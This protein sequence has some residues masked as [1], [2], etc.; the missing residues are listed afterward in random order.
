[1]VRVEPPRTSPAPPR[2]SRLVAGLGLAAATWA[3]CSSARPPAADLAELGEASWYGIEE[4]GRP[5]ANGEPMDPGAMT[6]AHPSLPF[7]TLVEV[8]DLSTGRS[9]EVRINDRGPF[10]AG[11]IIDL[12]H[13][14]ARRLGI[15]ARGVASVRIVIAARAPAPVFTVQ[16]G[17]YRSEQAARRISEEIRSHGYGRAQVIRAG[18]VH[19]VR[20]GQFSDRTDA[21]AL[22]AGL[23][24][25][26]YDALVIR[27][28]L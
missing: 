10:V 15:L 21:E 19:R 8:T 1:M 18:D 7:G 9:V 22:A 11:R 16:V 23:A 14:A 4:R 28:R 13:E 2:A 3:G 26:G 5:T 17:A 12:S 27:L 24:G 6:A 20:I 25:G